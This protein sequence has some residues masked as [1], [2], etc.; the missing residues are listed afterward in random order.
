MSLQILLSTYNGEK[1]IRTQLDSLL[2][3]TYQDFKVLIRDDG[4]MDKT[5]EILEEY[6]HQDPRIVWYG[7]ENIGVV[8][9][10]F[11]LM[12]H[13]DMTCDYFA[14]SDQD[15]EWLPEKLEKAV[16]M[17]QTNNSD[18][19]VLY[20]SDKIIVNE[21]LM[22]MDVHVRRDIRRPS[23]GN[24]LVQGICTGCTAV[25]NQKLMETLIKHMPNHIENIVMH[26]W[27]LYMTAS[28]FGKVCYDKGAYI[29]YRQ[30]QNNKLGAMITKRQL[31]FYRLK[32]L[33][34]P[35]GLIYRQVKEF[36][37]TFGK[38]MSKEN[39]ALA[40]DLLKAEKSVFSRIKI[41]KSKDIFRHKIDDNLVFR[42]IL[43]LGKL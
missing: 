15:D 33:S 26:D 38:E 21:D 40:T 23:F 1:Y 41:L 32:Q 24:A 4:S 39:V 17:L 25:W 5:P 16:K 19:P 13:A 14:F 31:F 20:C 28:C 43:M 30:H 6:T 37:A 8:Y 22:P 29:R 42:I 18:D 36:V 7:C 11:D 35:R 34:E 3:Q 27:W 10:F 12:K 9:S 2:A